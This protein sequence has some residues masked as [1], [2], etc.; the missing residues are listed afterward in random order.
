DP[1]EARR[2]GY[3]FDAMDAHYQA[4]YEVARTQ[5]GDWPARVEDWLRLAAL[6][7]APALEVADMRGA[8]ALLL[9]E[10]AA[11]QRAEHRGRDRLKRLLARIP[12]HGGASGGGGDAPPADLLGAMLA[13]AP[14]EGGVLASPEPLAP[15]P[16]HG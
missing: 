4:L 15:L 11:L 3:R 2:L 14:R 1:A 16:G 9:L 7:R 5:P 12:G 10:E 6:E 13:D 8:A